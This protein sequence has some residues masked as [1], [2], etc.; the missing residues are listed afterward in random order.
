MCAVQS[1]MITR[2]SEAV[3][4][5]I[6]AGQ[7]ITVPGCMRGHADHRGAQMCAAHRAVKRRVETVN[8]AVRADFPIAVVAR[9]CHA[10]DWSV[11]VLSTHSAIVGSIYE[12]KDADVRANNP[13]TINNDS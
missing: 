6:R 2:R 5:A 8:A 12:S 9:R 7:P 3:H 1:A 4:R 11:E 13:I 10:D